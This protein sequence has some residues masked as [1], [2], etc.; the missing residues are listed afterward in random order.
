M[1][2]HIVKKEGVINPPFTKKEIRNVM[3]MP[4]FIVEMF[5][6]GPCLLKNLYLCLLGILPSSLSVWLIK[7]KV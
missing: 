3:R 7:K 1:A 6:P 5:K 2:M 4:S